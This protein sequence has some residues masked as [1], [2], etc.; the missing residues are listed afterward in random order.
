M[1][2]KNA[3]SRLVN[4][5]P[6][7]TKKM[8]LVFLAIMLAQCG[9]K[10]GKKEQKITI[11][12]ENDFT[13]LD[14]RK[15]RL[16]NDYNFLTAVNE[17][18]FRMSEKGPVP[19][20]AKD[21]TFSEDL[22][23]CTITLKRTV[24]SNGDPLTAH[25]FAYAWKSLLKK[26]FPAPNAYFLFPI[27]HA[28]E[29]KKGGL[30]SSDLGVKVIDDY[31]LEIYLKKP[32]PH[33]LE[34]L[35]RPI[36]FPV[37]RHLD[38]ITPTWS[39]KG[40]S[41]LS[42]GP[43]LIDTHLVGSKIIVKKNPKYWDAEN[44]KLDTIEMVM[45]DE[46]TAYNLFHEK[47]LDYIGSPFSNIP[48]EAL[49]IEEKN[50]NLLH[51]PFLGTYWIRTNT[52]KSALQNIHLRKALALSIDRKAISHH[53][54][55]DTLETAT[56]VVP[57]SIH[58]QPK[59]LFKDADIERAKYHLA[60]AKEELTTIPP[61]HFSFIS[62]SVNKSVAL[63]LQDL[64]M[65]N[66]GIEIVIDPKQDKVFFDCL[67]KGQ[68]DLAYSG[69]TADFEDPLNFLEMFKDKHGGTNNTFWENSTYK[70]LLEKSTTTSDAEKRKNFLQVAEKL[71]IEDMPVIPMHHLKITY[72]KN[73]Q[74][75]GLIISKTGVI[76]FKYA[77]LSP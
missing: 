65:K 49:E 63:I 75:Q 51:A 26:D 36:T 47:E 77:Y 23:K 41:H 68:F 37:H 4:I 40:L 31:C 10:E 8:L 32:L 22:K 30:D 16:L 14:P 70:Q 39:S 13:T 11:N 67:G 69:K 42:N 12:I 7:I 9:K 6:S 56:G 2:W 74:L 18:L 15:T 43:F 57:F 48:T 58:L 59:R 1:Y 28:E 25:D 38:T 66:L 35:C 34:L 33:L 21:Y 46:R 3:F 72:L 60:K 29:I 17:G 71:L 52:N 73:Q 76:D 54:F 19:A 50:G 53:L 45:L 20:I 24:W 44:V 55:H 64:W 62:T 61:L 5:F 27:V